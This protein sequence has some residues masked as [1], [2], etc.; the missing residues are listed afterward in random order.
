VTTNLRTK[1]SGNADLDA[2]FDPYVQGTHPGLTG[3]NVGGTATDINTRFAPIVWGSAAAA[4]GFNIKNTATDINTLFAAFGTAHYNAP[5]PI[6]GQTF[7]STSSSA[8][9]N[10]SCSTTFSTTPSTW[11]VS[12]SSSG[13]GTV[14]SVVSGAVPSGAVSVM[15]TM[16]A[17]TVLGAGS[18]TNLASTRTMLSGTLG[19]TVAATSVPTSGENERD[20][21][22]VINYYNA[23]G[24]SISTTTIDL[25]AIATGTA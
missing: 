5:L 4:T 2:V 13:G 9:G 18:T 22:L 1:Q 19:A 6:G 20:Y 21:T 14:P 3:L 11:T 10:T 7:K 12:G 15:F 8:T 25:Q 17:N 24:A 23:A 16:T